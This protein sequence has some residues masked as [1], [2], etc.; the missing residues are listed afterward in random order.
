[1]LEGK[2]GTVLNAEGSYR[3]IANEIPGGLNNVATYN[4]KGSAKVL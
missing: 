2:E 3:A 4:V 1:M